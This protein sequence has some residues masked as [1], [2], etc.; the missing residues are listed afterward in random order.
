MVYACFH[1]QSAEWSQILSRQSWSS[2][3][4]AWAQRQMEDNSDLSHSGLNSPNR[5][6]GIMPIELLALNR[7]KS[8]MGLPLPYSHVASVWIHILCRLLAR[9]CIAGLF[10]GEA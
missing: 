8:C 7:W 2:A 1:R 5:F 3:S 10:D 6:L 4:R 9:F